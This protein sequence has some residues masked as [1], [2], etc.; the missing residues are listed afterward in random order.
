MAGCGGTVLL[1]YDIT[2]R[3]S[4]EGHYSDLGEATF[5]PSGEIGYEVGAVSGLLYFINSDLGRARREGF[6]L[7]GRAG[8]GILENDS[9]EVPFDQLNDGH[10]LVGIGAEYGLENGLGFRLEATSHDEDI[11]YGQGSILYR[12]G[13]NNRRN[14]AVRTPVTPPAP[15][16]VEPAVVQPV[17]V[18]PPAE[19]P[20]ELPADE[21]LPLPLDS[22]GDGIQD[23]SDEC[24]NT[25]AGTP[26]GD[27]GC[28]FFVGAIDGVSF[29][30]NSDELTSS[31][32]GVL[33]EVVNVLNQYPDARISIGA[34]TDSQGP[35]EQ[36]LQ[37]SKSRAIAV[38]RF[39]VEQ[40][41]D[42]S[43]LT[44]QAFGESRPVQ[45]NETT[46]GRAANRRVEFNLL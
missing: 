43:R 42:G 13:S 17:P 44:P 40:G 10:L 27:N 4:V 34:H 35:G 1:G 38:T 2:P 7:F 33:G 20:E 24:N 41:I 5:D 6:S 30:S 8:V 14:S 11:L 3:F 26:I 39:L 18:E 29:A 12:F 16:P 21:P 32:L 31:A 22:D 9:G 23:T 15:E 36:N 25:V 45:S 19:L 28:A 46:S 37:L